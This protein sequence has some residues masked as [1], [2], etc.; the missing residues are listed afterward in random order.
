MRARLLFLILLGSTN[1]AF[2]MSQGEYLARAA[3]CM[4]CHTAS[5]GEPLAGGV[6]FNTPVGV[7]YSTNITPDKTHGIGHYTLDDFKR[8]MTEGEAKDGHQLYPAMPYPSYVKMKPDDIE[9]IYHYLMNEVKPQAVANRETDIPW[10]LSMR[11]PLS[12]WNLINLEEGEFQPDEARSASW[13]RG[14]YLV[15]GPGHCGA[16]HTPR[17]W[18]EQEKA[19]DEK[20]TL[21]LSGAELDG[22]FAPSL[23]GLPY[24]Q[25]ELVKLLKQGRNQSSA[26]NGPMEEVVRHST[27]Y[28]GNDDLTAMAEYIYS[29]PVTPQGNKP[30]IAAMSQRAEAE[31]EKNY[32]NYCSTCHGVKGEGVKEVIPSLHNNLIVMAD[33]PKT[34]IRVALG[35]AKTPV[36][37]TTFQ[38]V[39]PGYAEILTD[40]QITDVLN[41]VR[42]S[43]GNQ[44]SLVKE[45]QVKEARR[46]K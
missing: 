22:W 18:M 12:V 24:S 30:A 20:E 14:A 29:L 4:A 9:A 35:G 31:G 6:K 40:K 32:L 13:N 33:N 11:W 10:P 38:Y 21:Y 15:Q 27:Q 3:D 2:A 16:C 46:G 34:L 41:Y 45:E 8:A 25:Q 36:T 26:V 42:G 44:A 19:L 1:S 7:I 17:G 23:R 39:M 37:Q 28:L 43:F 5:E